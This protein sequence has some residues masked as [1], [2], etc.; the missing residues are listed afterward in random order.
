[1]ILKAVFIILTVLVVGFVLLVLLGLLLKET[2][3]QPNDGNPRKTADGSAEAAA[4]IATIGALSSDAGTSCGSSGG[5]AS[6]SSDS[7][8]SSS[9]SSD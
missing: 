6:C 1:M 5:D 4:S 3:A 7:S 8:S 9:S 2:Q